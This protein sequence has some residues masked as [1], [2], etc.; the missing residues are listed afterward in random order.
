MKKVA[1]SLG[2]TTAV[3]LFL[4]ASLNAQNNESEKF[5]H[6]FVPQIMTRGEYRHGYQSLADTN[7]KPAVFIG[8]RTRLTY[9][10]TSE[11]F[12]VVIT[13]QDIRTWGSNPNLPVD[14]SGKLSLAEGYGVIKFDK[15]NKL[16]IGRQIISYDE[17]RILGS[18][19]WAFQSRRH[20]LVVFEHKN[21]T[22]LTFHV[23]AAWNQNKDYLNTTVYTVPGNYKTMQY[24]W[25]FRKMKKFD[26]SVL[27]L[28]NGTQLTKTDPI[29]G[30]KKY[31]DE[32]SQTFGFNTTI[33]P[34]Q[35]LSIKA[36]AYYQMGFDATATNASGNAKAINAYDASLD[37]NYKILEWF[38]SSIGGEIL[39]GTSQD[40]KKQNQLNSFNPLY[41]TNHRFNGYMDYFYVGNHL[42]NV[43]LVDAYLKL[44][45]GKGNWNVFV[46]V[47]NFQAAADIK[48]VKK[49][50]PSQ[51]V[52]MDKQLGQEVDVTFLY[53]IS[54]G[55]SI[56]AGY[57]QMF[58]TESMVAL[59]G[60]NTSA[61][62]NWAYIMFHFRPGVMFPRTGLKQ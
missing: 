42:K 27:F 7:Q 31:Y 36:F 35:K 57:S 50:T 19:D 18:L 34:I 4:T 47:H 51:F 20:D 56:Q 13:A 8:Q 26:I 48:D 21:D 1:F 15:V 60:G 49:S 9:K 16:K 10:L 12:D 58:G 44:N 17:D 29:T 37:V 32:F 28:N 39:S 23:G 46:N 41:G 11:K 25:L 22:S 3:A 61:V 24:L 55:V 52:A 38:N 14:T 5:K 33:K 2:K 30:Q 40:P 6:E 45:F 54:E 59:K 62:S 43:G 53:K